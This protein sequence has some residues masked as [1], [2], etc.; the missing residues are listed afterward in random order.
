MPIIQ[1]VDPRLPGQANTAV[2][3]AKIDQ[4]DGDRL[5]RET[6]AAK[7]NLLSRSAGR[8]N[9]PQGLERWQVEIG[10][11]LLHSSGWAVDWRGDIHLPGQGADK[12]VAQADHGAVAPD[13]DV[14]ITV[15]D[16]DALVTLAQVDVGDT[17]MFGQILILDHDVGEIGLTQAQTGRVLTNILEGDGERIAGVGAS[18]ESGSWR[19][20]LFLPGR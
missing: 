6:V 15:V 2:R 4:L 13:I 10:S 5:L 19:Y 11:S 3:L 17:V 8:F 9:H 7:G 14:D 18:E 12:P 20:G 16:F 1:L